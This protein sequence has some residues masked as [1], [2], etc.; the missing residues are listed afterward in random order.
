MPTIDVVCPSGLQGV[1]R[2]LRGAELDLFANADAVRN[3][4]VTSQILAACWSGSPS[5]SPVYAK[6]GDTIKW[7][8]V[9]VADRFY[10]IFKVREAT[11]GEM[12]TPTLRCVGIGSCGHKFKTDFNLNDLEVFDLPQDTIDS[13]AA[14]I[15]E[16]KF[17]VGDATVYHQVLYGKDEARIEK[18]KKLTP[19]ELATTSMVSRILRV[20]IPSHAIPTGKGSPYRAIGDGDIKTLSGAD[21]RTWVRG[22][23]AQDWDSVRD[24]LETVDGGIDTEICVTCPKCGNEIE[25]DLPLDPSEFWMQ[26]KRDASSKRKGRHASRG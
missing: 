5:S 22:L 6:M 17:Q 26:K 24:G 12:Y 21:L 14:G 11:R 18:N 2:G 15:N 16:F 10:T 23:E 13:L 25:G 19:E 7:D 20:E 9:L 8:D 1:V 4:R 3:N